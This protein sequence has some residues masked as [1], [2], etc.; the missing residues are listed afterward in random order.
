MEDA[1]LLDYLKRVTTELQSTRERLRLVETAAV[2]PVAIVGMGCRFPGG[3]RSPELFWE[4]LAD[5]VDALSE[6]P[7]DR[8]WDLESLHHPDPDHRGTSYVREGGF[9]HDAA[10]FDAE[11]FGISPREAL[12]MDPQ[13]RLLLETSWEAVER[14][15]IDPR[16][17]RGTRTGVFAGTN[18]QDYPAVLEGVAGEVE[19]YAGTGSAASVFSGRVAYCLGLEGPALSVDT[20]CSSSLVALHLAVQSLRRGECALALAGGATVMATPGVFVEFSRQRGLAA[21]GRCKAFAEAADGTGWG[22]GVGVLLLERLS[23][24]RRNGHPVLAV[25]RGSAVNQDGASNG[26][27]APNGPSQRRVILDALADAGLSTA[28]VDAV[29]AHGTGTTLGDPIEAQ[30]LLATYGLGRVRPLLLGSVKSNL[31]H[32]QAAAGVAGVIKMVLALRRGFLPRTL[33]VDAPSSRVDW[34]AGKVELLTRGRSWPETGAP[35]RAGVSS[36]GVSGTNAH[37]ILEQAPEGRTPQTPVDSAVPLVLSAKGEA[38]LRELGERLVPA[39]GAG[40]ADVGHSL[41]VSRSTWEQRAVLVTE[42]GSAEAGLTALAAGQEFPGLVRGVATKRGKVAFVFPGQGSQ[43]VGMG[44]GLRES[45]PVFAARLDECA[46]ALRSFVDWDL[47]G[48]L[49]DPGALGRVDV[50]QPVLWAVMVSLA[51]VW[52]SYGVRPAAVVGHSQGEIAAA[53]VSGALSLVDGARV[54]ALRSRAIRALAGRGGMVSVALPADRVRERLVSGLSVAA[55]NGPESTVVSGDLLALEEF[56]AA[57]ERDGLRVKRIPVDYASHSAHVEEIREELLEVLGPISPVVGRVPLLS[58]VTGELVEGSGLD[59]AYWYRNLRRTVEFERA[60]RSLSERGFGTFIEVSAHPV[61]TLGV[62]QTAED[63]LVVGTLRRDEDGL[64][65]VLL[66]LAEAHVNGVEVDWS[67]AFPGA[68]RVDLPTYPFQRRRFW[69]TT[70]EGDLDDLTPVVDL[71]DGGVVLAGRLAVRDW[72]ADHVLGDEVVLPGTAFLEVAVRAGDVVGC[73]HVDVMTLESPLVLPDRGSAEVRVVIGPDRGARSIEVHSRRADEDDWTRHATGLI[74]VHAPAAPAVEPWPPRGATRLPLDEVSPD[75]R[76][77][78]QRGDEVFAEVA[79]SAVEAGDAHR[80]GLH[81]ALLDAGIRATA[82]GGGERRPFEWTGFTLHASG[83]TAMRLRVAPAGADKVS[84]TASD[85][86]GALVAT[87]DSLTSREVPTS[88]AVDRRRALFALEWT[89]RTAATSVVRD[90]VTTAHVAAP[91]GTGPAEAAHLLA[92]QVLELLRDQLAE[93]RPGVL[94]VVTRGAVTTPVDP[95]AAAVWGLVRAAQREHPGRFVLVDVDEHPESLRALP[96]AVALGEPEVALREGEVLLPSLTKGVARGDGL[97]FTGVVLVTGAADGLAG[98]VARHLV[99]AHGVRDLVLVSRRGEVAPGSVDLRDELAA[100]GAR[101]LLA[102]CDVADRAALAA[103]LDQ[104]GPISSV[105][106][107]AAV[108]DDAVITSLTSDAVDRVLRAKADAVVNLHELAGEL[109]AFVVF[110]SASGTLGGAGMG[111]YGAANA[112]LDAFARHR[113]SLGL[114]ALSLA[115]GLWERAGGMA[116]RLGQ[117]SLRRMG[118]SG[119][120]AMSDAE[121]LA[122]FDAACRT[123]ADVVLPMRLDP[124]VLRDPAADLPPLLRGQARPASRRAV[125]VVPERDGPARALDGLFGAE[126]EEHLL[127]LVRAHAAAVLGHDTPKAVA[128]D[129]SFKELGFDSLTGV[130]LRNRL[131]AATGLRLPATLVFDHPTPRALAAELRADLGEREHAADPLG[132]EV[133]LDRLEAALRKTELSAEERGDIA[134]R[135]RDA[136]AH[137]DPGTAANEIESATD[138]ELFQLID[139]KLGTL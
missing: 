4:L 14:A 24:A 116:G 82:T 118:R 29:E 134:A 71:P 92:G 122:L 69:P 33:H 38:S 88:E 51:A 81:P 124:D 128:P 25:V 61:L 96:A 65:R 42:V 120:A 19:G 47:L 63:A 111:G 78:W 93:D 139:R 16:S 104:V 66:S 131:G 9:L 40:L 102:A 64:D 135:L 62:Q 98:L 31:G 114:P 12:A 85:L 91:P 97:Q 11:F 3:A 30:A 58:A 45:C 123:G 86:T 55:V 94:A 36:F 57:A 27:T 115:W 133:L 41:L 8:G 137:A 17:L 70:Q 107:A 53:C 56:F 77:L 119:I 80:F 89:A 75:V 10:E 87:V 136:A 28:D 18:G 112:F 101:V 110:S 90:D 117:A 35:R 121:G 32:A 95:A 108:L 37:V 103:L 21:D 138:D 109:D 127:D 34:S 60:V 73:A 99:A 44:L 126:L 59:A 68:H 6:F 22:E 26:L 13:Q 43:W 39:L 105:V 100:A 49:G 129:H 20:A 76:E 130:E 54:V 2:E 7:T 83:A 5:G 67:P 52:E 132:V 113:R 23:D 106:H 74:S 125:A 46:E 79:L 48:V 84:I 72:F 1:K 50:V 15:G